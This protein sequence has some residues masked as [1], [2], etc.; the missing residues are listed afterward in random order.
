M[1]LPSCYRRL[2]G[3]GVVK[4]G[5]LTAAVPVGVYPWA[6]GPDEQTGEEAGMVP[7]LKASARQSIRFWCR[8]RWNSGRVGV[9]S[10]F[11]SL[12]SYCC[13]KEGGER[14]FLCCSASVSNPARKFAGL[15]VLQGQRGGAFIIGS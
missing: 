7:P 3:P 11:A 5:A 12:L 6:L 14:L 13:R 10:T 8:R 4:A 1:G 15:N 2:E 9:V